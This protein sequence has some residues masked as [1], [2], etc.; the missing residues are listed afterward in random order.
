MSPL[1]AIQV[2]FIWSLGL[3]SCVCVCVC[4]T[5]LN[6]QNIAY[7]LTF[8][9]VWILTHFICNISCWYIRTCLMLACDHTV[10]SHECLNLTNFFVQQIRYKYF[11][12]TVLLLY[13]TKIT[14]YSVVESVLVLH[15]NWHSLWEAHVCVNV[16]TSDILLNAWSA[17]PQ[18]VFASLRWAIIAIDHTPITTGATHIQ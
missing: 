11:L 2:F 18:C 7:L 1:N 9:I 12:S 5:Q 3:L 15:M 13:H 6:T 8:I 14:N 17:Q 4:V 10:T 16:I